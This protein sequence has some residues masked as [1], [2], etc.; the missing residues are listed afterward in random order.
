MQATV[1][2]S[3][4]AQ[5]ITTGYHNTPPPVVPTA[6]L[7]MKG[8]DFYLMGWSSLQHS[9]PTFKLRKKAFSETIPAHL[10]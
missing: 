9:D 6:V 1:V 5:H 3:K 7:I 10:H 8:K 2:F 4:P